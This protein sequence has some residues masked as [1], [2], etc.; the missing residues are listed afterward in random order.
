MPQP[1]LDLSLIVT[2]LQGQVSAL[3]RVDVAVDQNAARDDL[4]NIYPAAY[5]L[6]MQDT[7]S[8]NALANAVSQD[9]THTFGVLVAVMNLGDTTGAKARSELSPIRSSIGDALLNWQPGNDYTPCEY[10]GG[11]LL[12]LTDRVMWWMDQYRTRFEVRMT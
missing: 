9:V 3:K 2:R 12:G 4:K 1:F 10:S 7:A 5:V 11:R 6:P 8:P